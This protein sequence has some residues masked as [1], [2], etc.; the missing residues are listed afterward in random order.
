MRLSKFSEVILELF[1]INKE[2]NVL[3]VVFLHALW[4]LLCSA[5]FAH[6]DH[7]SFP[8]LACRSSILLLFSPS[9]YAGAFELASL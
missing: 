7:W 4:F 8:L 6:R 3:W 2:I 9:T 5:Y 1:M